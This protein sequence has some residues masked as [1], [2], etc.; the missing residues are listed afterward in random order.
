M[1]VTCLL[2]VHAK[3]AKVFR[4]LFSVCVIVMYEKHQA[5]HEL[6]QVEKRMRSDG[7]QALLKKVDLDHLLDFVHGEKPG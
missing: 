2:R 7:P 5:G 3:N 6:F 4:C 1:N